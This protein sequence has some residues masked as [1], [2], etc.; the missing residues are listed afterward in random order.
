MSKIFTRYGDGTPVEL[1]ES[2]LW[3]DMRAGTEDAADRANVPVLTDDDLKYMY[4]ILASP[5]SF[6]SCERGKEVI[7]TYDAGT[8]KIRRVGVNVDRIQ[9]LQVYEKIMGAD[10][11]ELC[12]VD[13]SYKPIK[14][15][16]TMEQPIMEQALLSTHIPL[17]YGAMPNLGLYSQPDGPFPNPAELL[18]MGQIKE[19]RESLEMTVEEAVR[20][21]VF[22]GSAMY[23]S[24]ADGINL[25]SVGAAGDADFL[26]SLMACQKL[27]EKYPDI[28]IQIGM[29]GEFILGMHGELEYDGVRLAG[30]YPQDQV[31]LAKKAGAT[32]FGPV[33]NTNTTESTPWNLARA[34]T[35]M[36]ACGEVA[37]IP[38]HPNMGM[39]VG[40]VPVN[41]H[42]PIDTVSRASAAMTSLCKLDGL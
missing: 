3:E 26:A 29:A 15:I 12:H 27:K 24:G 13:Y 41:D 34:V 2:E 21:I 7:L 8:L 23:E 22:T 11:M 42:P 4:D 5:Y 1:S 18:P 19:A 30:L 33:V 28:C 17:L 36:K 20:D 40:A 6:V 37:E 39:G 38:I 9:A 31:V 10:T 16:I 35:F 25:D 32:I 14:P